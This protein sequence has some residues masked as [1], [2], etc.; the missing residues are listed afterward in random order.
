MTLTNNILDERIKNILLIMED[1][2]KLPN[3]PDLLKEVRQIIQ[4]DGT[5]LNEWELNYLILDSINRIIQSNDTIKNYLDPI[6]KTI[7]SQITHHEILKRHKFYSCNK[8]III[9]DIKY[10]SSNT[11]ECVLND[12]FI[13]LNKQ[14]E[15]LNDET[16]HDKILDILEDL[17]MDQQL[18]SDFGDHY[19]YST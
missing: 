18:W 12:F 5:F 9:N 15:I 7:N 1:F 17:E 14:K 13:Y 11:F 8:E 6:I 19:G 3:F 10:I 2:K 16:S 4:N